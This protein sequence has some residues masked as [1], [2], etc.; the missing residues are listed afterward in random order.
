MFK[1]FG[2]TA[3]VCTVAVLSLSQSPAAQSTVPLIFSTTFNCPDWNQGMGL[4]DALVCATGD[5]ILG[6]GAWTTSAGSQ[7]Q[8]VA[9]ANNPAGTGKGFRHWR[10][11]GYN[12]NGG[13]LRIV[14]PAAATKMWVRFYMRYQAGF[15]WQNGHPGGTKETYWNVG[16]GARA[17]YVGFGFGQLRFVANG[18]SWDSNYTWD[19]LNQGSVGDGRWHCIEYF[20][21]VDTNGSN[22]LGKMWVDGVQII[23]ATN[24]NWNGGPWTDFHLGSNQET[25]INGH[26]FYTDY[27]D[28]AISTSGYIGPLTGGATSGGVPSAPTNLRIF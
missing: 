5:G 28:I 8:I 11:D 6:S 25:P 7:D 17:F 1:K 12:N 23:N 22:G 19:Q 16:Q 21:Q 20:T 4:T 14:L 18:H 24:V 10:G 3:S 13:G 9:A 2:F 26:D 15:A 27:D